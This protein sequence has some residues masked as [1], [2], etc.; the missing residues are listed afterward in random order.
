MSAPGQHAAPGERGHQPKPVW[1]VLARR[2]WDEALRQ[3][4]TVAAEDP[5]MAAV[6]AQSIYDEWPWIEM[7]V[8]PRASM[9]TVIAA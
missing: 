4:G 8:F 5:E 3:V 6:Y 7:V 1:I 9:K 2:N